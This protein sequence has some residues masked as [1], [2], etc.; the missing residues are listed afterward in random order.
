M[1]IGKKNAHHA[2]SAAEPLPLVLPSDMLRNR[3]V[4]GMK[5]QLKKKT[6]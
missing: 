2:T 4:I 1:P 5:K 3:P 6:P